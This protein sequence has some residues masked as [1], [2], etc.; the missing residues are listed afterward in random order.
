MLDEERWNKLVKRLSGNV[1]RDNS[2][3]RIIAAYSESHRHYHTINH[4]KHC[5]SEFDAVR[6]FFDSP[7]EAEFAIWLHDVVYDTHASD[8]EEKSAQIAKEILCESRC[9]EMKVKKIQGLI[10][11]TKHVQPPE[12]SDAQLIVDIDLAIL[13]QPAEIFDNY[14]KNIRAEYA[15][16]SEEDYKIGRAKVLQSF[17]NRPSI[18]NTSRFEKLYEHQARENILKVLGTLAI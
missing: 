18:F 12:T 14:E 1:S 3:N 7:D 5:L 10:L 11:I 13:G 4:I 15:W 16:V 17:Y 9:P 8:N 6:G 2:F